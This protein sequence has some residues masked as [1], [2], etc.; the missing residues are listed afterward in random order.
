MRESVLGESGV[1]PQRIQDATRGE[2]AAYLRDLHLR[3]QGLA[4][5]HGLFVAL[6]ELAELRLHRWLQ[7]PLGQE[8]Q[9]RGLGLATGQ[10]SNKTNPSQ[11]I[12][13]KTHWQ[14]G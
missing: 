11:R 8:L 7:G 4:L 3:L 9:H 13:C 12:Q 6:L 14:N 2:R 10:A 1:F 5:L